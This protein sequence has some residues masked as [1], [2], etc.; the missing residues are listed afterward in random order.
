MRQKAS[1]F[2]NKT[3]SVGLKELKNS[4]AFIKYSNGMEKIYG[5]FEE[6]NPDKEL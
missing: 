1:C 2:I 5:N 4:K 3:K 6:H